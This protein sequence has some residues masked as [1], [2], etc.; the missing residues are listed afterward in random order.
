MNKEKIL[1]AG[2]IAKQAKD[3]IK[4]LIKKDM[5]LLD[6]AEKIEAKIIELG[7]KVAFPTS[8]AIDDVAAHYTP[9]PDDT[10]KAQGLLKVDLGVHID[11]FIADTAFSVD[12]ENNEENKK[13]I[14]ASEDALKNAI[15][16]AKEN[17]SLSQIGKT[18]SNTI[19]SHSFFPIINL[20]GHEMK[21]YDLHAGMTVPNIDDK[22]NI[23]LKKGLYA[24]EPFA[25]IGVGKVHD[26]KPSGIYILT[27]TKK[28]RSP[29]ARQVLDFIQEEYET[30]PF[31]SRWIVKKFG[32][33]SLFA[34]SQLEQNNN[35]H[36]FP[37]LVEDSKNKV[38]QAENTILVDD[39][40][41]IVTTE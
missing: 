41:V 9:S 2:K 10:T 3:Y 14:E 6:I 1:K 30:L 12:L 38:A 4:P 33:T 28:P 32:K 5:L 36:H 21:E 37:Q 27:D 11:G 24:I 18:I 17:I 39:E 8:L 34:L 7:G 23:P 31:C 16:I 15:K 25:T 35:L 29:L 22:K 40:G 20:S 26:G 13:L 19:E